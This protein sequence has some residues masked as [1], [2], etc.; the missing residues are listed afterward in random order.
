MCVCVSVYVFFGWMG[1]WEDS[2]VA[3]VISSL[4]VCE[5]ADLSQHRLYRYRKEV[6]ICSD[7]QGEPIKSPE[8]ATNSSINYSNKEHLDCLIDRYQT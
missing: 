1:G 7:S 5:T 8:L 6:F 4:V 3:K 2:W